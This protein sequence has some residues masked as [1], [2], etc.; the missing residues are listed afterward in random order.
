MKQIPPRI[1][2]GSEAYMEA[3]QKTENPM[4]KNTVPKMKRKIDRRRLLNGSDGA[5]SRGG[6]FGSNLG[7]FRVP[8]DCREK[9]AKNIKK[10]SNF[11]TN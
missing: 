4:S 5:C 11:L 8:I 9:P 3:F 1:E 2:N 7:L 6:G 10:K